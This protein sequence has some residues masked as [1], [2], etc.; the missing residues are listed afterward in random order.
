MSVEAELKHDG[1]DELRCEKLHYGVCV[2]PAQHQAQQPHTCPTCPSQLR[3]DEP[4]DY[5]R[6]Q[7]PTAGE[8]LGLPARRAPCSG[9]PT[10]YADSAVHAN[11]KDD[12]VSPRRELKCDVQPFQDSP[13][14]LHAIRL[15]PIQPQSKHFTEPE[16]SQWRWPCRLFRENLEANQAD[17]A[18]NRLDRLGN[19]QT[20]E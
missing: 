11:A 2:E 10:A 4:R 6:R 3:P 19:S 20:A 15:L 9:V 18:R 8:H 1:V 12:F 14:S 16:R 5:S 7:L 17:A 13:G